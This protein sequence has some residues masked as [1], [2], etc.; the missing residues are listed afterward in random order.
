LDASL[1]LLPTYGYKEATAPRMRSTF[2]RIHEELAHN[3]LLHRYPADT[4]DGF[5]SEEGAFG[6]CSFWD[7]ELFA[8]LGRVDEAR[9]KL[10]E[11]ISYAN[12]L[13]LF[14]EEIDVET[15]AFL[16]NFPQAF[17]HV[18]LINA[19]ITIE[20]VSEDAST[21]YKQPDSAP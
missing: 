19:A 16:G 15:G 9:E 2:A 20:K 3:G 11:T 8:R 4:D 17:T 7:E 21:L 1:L 10:T 13:G 12:D 18:G 6:I 5:S 14:A